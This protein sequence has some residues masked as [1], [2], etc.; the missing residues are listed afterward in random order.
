MNPMRK[1]ILLCLLA[2]AALAPAFAVEPA[3]TFPRPSWFR[4]HF[5]APRTKV[6]L[7]APRRLS[8]YVV[9]GK[10]ELSLRAYI[11]LVLANS[12]DIALARLQVESPANAITRA[13]SVFD[14]SVSASFTSTRATETSI[15]AL[16][17]ASTIKLLD[18]P[19]S[20]SYSQLLPSGTSFSVGFYADRTSTNYAY[21]TYNPVLS[22]NLSVQIQHQLLRDRGAAMEKLNILL[23]RSNLKISRYQLRDQVTSLIAN[24]ENAYWNV[25]EAR[26]TE[27]LAAQFVALKEASL[28]RAQKQMDSGALLPLD[29]YQPKSEYASARLNQIQ[30]KRAL[31]QQEN[32]LRQQIGADLDPAIRDMPIALT[33]PLEIPV[34]QAPDKTEAVRKAMAARPDR[35]AL[36]AALDNDDIGIR[37]A[38]E[39]LRPTVA[40]VGSYQSQGI[41][42]T[43]LPAAI[44]GG[45]GD[46]LSQM[47]QFKFPVYSFGLQ[48]KL[49]IRDH[50]AAA[51]LADA[52]IRK[53]TDALNLRK[54][55][56]T[57]R[58]QV[59][60]AVDNVEAARASLEQAQLARDYAGKRF[61][62]EQKK[63]ELGISY[64]F[65]LQQSQTDFN[66]TE[67]NVL[68]QN[69]TYRRNLVNLYSIMGQLLDERGITLD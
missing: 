30:A 8:E 46:A 7:Q 19:W 54:L 57:L 69:I 62:S 58:L 3:F 42:G 11:E 60:N 14:P 67:F 55:E 4:Q 41:G 43:Y 26:E 34:V 50:A 31:S 45:F 68:E 23:A 64:L 17:G 25:V 28:E 5:A 2:A 20:G 33:E 40:L 22:S 24:A 36:A 27:K 35:L 63:Y 44:P 10:L 6:E 21:N 9:N 38:N 15:N 16:Q 1:P 18:Q 48:M 37:R 51:D 56:Q 53:K 39:A 61:E 49:P 47:F 65:L 13:F 52:G 12:T 29:I 32:A 59:L 66:T